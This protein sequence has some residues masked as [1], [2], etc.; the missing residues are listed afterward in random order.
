MR[1]SF[2][3]CEA[4]RAVVITSVLDDNIVF[5]SKLLSWSCET[6]GKRGRTLC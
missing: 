4:E 2:E 5:G 6:I 3:Y 1:A